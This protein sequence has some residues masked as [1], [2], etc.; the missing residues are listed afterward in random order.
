MGTVVFDRDWV[1]VARSE[2]VLDLDQAT[3]AGEADRALVYQTDL[4][5]RPGTYWIASQVMGEAGSVVGTETQEV[6]VGSFG[7]GRL[8]LSTPELAFFVE[9]TG[10]QRFRKRDV[11][12]VPNATGEIKGGEVLVLYFEIYN[13]T[14][15]DGRS[16]YSVAYRIA[17]HDREGRSLFARFVG[18]FS[19]KTFVESSFVEEGAG[20]TVRRNLSID[21]GTLPSDRY[22]LD[23]EVT[24][25]VSGAVAARTLAFTRTKGVE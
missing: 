3:I 15:V 9:A 24:D 21:V 14:A 6:S 8:E 22:R 19:A 23:L 20:P 12:V 25:L 11:S 16:R 17:P 4:E 2:E 13:L 1:E 18:A 5:L 7:H 10:P